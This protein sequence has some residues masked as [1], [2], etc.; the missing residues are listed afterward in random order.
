M[1]EV[2]CILSTSVFLLA[3]C[4][5]AALAQPA[6]GSVAKSAVTMPAPPDS[7]PVTVKGAT[8]ALLVFDMVDPIC[9]YP[10][11]QVHPNFCAA[12]HIARG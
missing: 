6:P 5:G 4:T 3:A 1:S 12:P 10:G 2:R 11:D 9:S 7:V 8:T